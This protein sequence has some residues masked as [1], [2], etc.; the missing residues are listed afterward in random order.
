MTGLSKRGGN[1]T[2]VL[3]WHGALH[4]WGHQLG[5]CHHHYESSQIRVFQENGQDNGLYAQVAGEIFGFLP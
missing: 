1:I 5:H 4:V 2:C 3:V